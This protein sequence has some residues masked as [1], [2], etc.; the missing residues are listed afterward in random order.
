M[1]STNINPNRMELRKVREKLK[2]ANKGHELLKDKTSG[3]IKIFYQIIKQTRDLRKDVEKELKEIYDGF[4]YSKTSLSDEEVKFL[5]GVSIRE[6][7]LNFG[8]VSH[9]GA[10][11]PE[12]T[13]SQQSE[14]KLLYSPLSSS[15]QFDLVSQ[16]FLALLPKIM[17]LAS[18][19]KSAYI[20][21]DEI[22]KCK[23]R[24]KALENMLI[25][26][27]KKDIARIEQKL[28]NSELE[29]TA[30]LKSVKKKKL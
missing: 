15:F 19:E 3:L 18:V 14:E 2:V 24:T 4:Q 28:S 6:F 21:A 26:Q 22:E 7:G 23:R 8:T 16:K 27:Y 30:M 13:I 9:L 10:I 5:L 11:C 20:L 1:E 29:N 12:I 25:P 17:E